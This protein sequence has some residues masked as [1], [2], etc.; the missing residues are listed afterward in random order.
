[1]FYRK[2]E[3]AKVYSQTEIAEGIYDCL[4][5]TEAA[6]HANAG[7]FIGIYPKDKS[8]LLVRPISICDVDRE[9]K[10]MRLVYR[11]AGENISEIR[12]IKTTLMCLSILSHNTGT[13]N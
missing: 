7:Q 8:H 11:V 10:R 1:M 3:T 9:N 4:I 13:V 12:Q 2:K 6:V 5:E